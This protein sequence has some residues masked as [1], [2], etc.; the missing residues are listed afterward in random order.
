MNKKCEIIDLVSV[1]IKMAK[2][3]TTNIIGIKKYIIF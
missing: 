2:I 3:I 1:I